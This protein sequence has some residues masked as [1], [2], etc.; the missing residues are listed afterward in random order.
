MVL[1]TLVALVL[2]ALLFRRLVIDYLFPEVTCPVFMGGKT[3][4]VTGGSSGLGYEIVLALASR[5]CKV[6]IADK[7]SDQS[8]RDEL[9]RKTNNP[10]ISIYHLDLGSFASVRA[11]AE[12]LRKNVD[13]V[14]ILFNNAGVGGNDQ[15]LTEDGVNFVYQINY[16]GGFLLTHLLLDLL[17]KSQSGK[18]FFTSSPVAYF[19]NLNKFDR[20]QLTTEASLYNY[21]STKCL[22]IICSD[23]F[24]DKLRQFNITSNAWHPIGAATQIFRG[25]VNQTK[26]SYTFIPYLLW[27]TA[28]ILTPEP[29]RVVMRAIYLACAKE[30]ESVSG[31]LFS[32]R[33]ETFKPPITRDK[34]FCQQIWEFSEEV[35]KLRPE[36]K[37]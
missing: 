12:Q 6:V 30:M 4:V 22:Y 32:P 15:R 9:I 23:Q 28:L 37:L 1:V 26:G 25:T 31:K 36:E 35:V 19:H 18:I 29:R 7:I 20:K 33:G 2:G 11:F 5:G 34:Q 24:A 17:K 21:S 8:I 16:Y 3:A 14:D 10:D 27:I 13:K